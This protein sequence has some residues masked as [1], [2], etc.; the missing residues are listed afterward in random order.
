MPRCVLCC[1]QPATCPPRRPFP[2]HP[3][4][5]CP[6]EFSFYSGLALLTHIDTCGPLKPGPFAPI[7]DLPTDTEGADRLFPS[8]PAAQLQQRLAQVQNN[9]AMGAGCVPYRKT[10]SQGGGQ[11]ITLVAVG[12]A[13]S[14][15]QCCHALRAFHPWGTASILNYCADEAG[16][17]VYNQSRTA[18]PFGP[19]IL[20]IA[21]VPIGTCLLVYSDLASKG[22]MRLSAHVSYDVGIWLGK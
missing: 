4:A 5:S 12:T 14:W 3:T 10:L 17:G 6:Q 7:T 16:C 19:P 11:N 21:T 8:L 9:G 20:P 1:K 13:L 15:D 2:L 22:D 18:P